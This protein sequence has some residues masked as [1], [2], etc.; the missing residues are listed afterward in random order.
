MKEKSPINELKHEFDNLVYES[1]KQVV[2]IILLMLLIIGTVILNSY[3]E[4]KE[5]IKAIYELV[6]EGELTDE[7]GD[8]VIWLLYDYKPNKYKK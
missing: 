3:L 4:K 7:Q 5:T 6:E 1:R 2:T 8:A